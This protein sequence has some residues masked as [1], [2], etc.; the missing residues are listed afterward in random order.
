VH[1]RARCVGATLHVLEWLAILT[2]LAILAVLVLVP[3]G[4]R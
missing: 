4:G 3:G 1:K 2:R